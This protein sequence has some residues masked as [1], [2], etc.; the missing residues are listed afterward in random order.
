MV[1]AAW[2]CTLFICPAVFR[3]HRRSRGCGAARVCAILAQ[4]NASQGRGGLPVHLRTIGG[5]GS[6]E[7][8]GGGTGDGLA[9]GLADAVAKVGASPAL[10]CGAQDAYARGDRAL[11]TMMGIGLAAAVGI[12]AM[13]TMDFAQG[14]G[15]SSPAVAGEAERTNFAR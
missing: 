6:T 4:A 14:K 9:A 2:G 8:R 7:I 5:S 10:Q 15:P 13:V 11:L 1:G 3:K 12:V